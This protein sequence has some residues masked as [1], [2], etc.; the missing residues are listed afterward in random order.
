ME[1]ETIAKLDIVEGD[2]LVVKTDMCLTPD[3]RQI[4]RH[5][6]TS[7]VLRAGKKCSVLILENGVSVEIVKTSQLPGV[8]PD[9][10]D[11]NDV[12]YRESAEFRHLDNRGK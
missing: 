1:I 5:D 4:L 8:S 2:V 7:A 6:V 10:F 12:P 3:Q 11:R 9:L